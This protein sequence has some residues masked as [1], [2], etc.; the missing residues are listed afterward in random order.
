MISSEGYPVC[1]DWRAGRCSRRFA[2]RAGRVWGSRGGGF[3]A[4]RVYR[5]AHRP[6][7]VGADVRPL[8]DGRIRVHDLP[9]SG[10]VSSLSGGLPAAVRSQ[11]NLR[12][13]RV[14]LSR[15]SHPFCGLLPR[16]LGWPGTSSAPTSFTATTGRLGWCP[17]TCARPWQ[18][19]HFPGRRTLFTIHNLGYQGLFP[20]DGDRGC[21]S[22]PR[23][24]AAR[25]AWNSSGRSAT[26]KAGSRSP[27]R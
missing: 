22:R 8:R 4:I 24:D 27:T 3:A 9:G 16:R 19:P 14:G 20:E 15:Q 6:A 13:E 23:A 12:R 18:R 11:G 21:R 5:F 1:K 10:G 7:R 2:L 25:T 26:S 17:R